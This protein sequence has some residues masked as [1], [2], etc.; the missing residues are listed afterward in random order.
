MFDE[1]LN[2]IKNK[3]EKL[4]YLYSK[5]L[6]NYYYIK[7]DDLLEFYESVVN[8]LSSIKISDKK[9]NYLMSLLNIIIEKIKSIVVMGNTDFNIDDFIKLLITNSYSDKK[10]AEDILLNNENIICEK[11]SSKLNEKFDSEESNDF[12]LDSKLSDIERESIRQEV[13]SSLSFSQ[14]SQTNADDDFDD[15]YFE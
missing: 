12:F 5:G 2:R 1:E 3:E 9:I 10:I 7:Y 6:L 13:I 15:F 8:N 11:I 4:L 14:T